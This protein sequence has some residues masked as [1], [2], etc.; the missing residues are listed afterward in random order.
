MRDTPN[1]RDLPGLKQRDF[2]PCALCGRGVAACGHVHFY[3]VRMEQ[4]VF[5]ANAIRRQHG[6][7]T[8][9]GQAAALAQALGPDEDLAK[10]VS[11]T[12]QLVCGECALT[13]D[14]LSRL[15]DGGRDA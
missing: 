4:F 12:E 11:V 10:R 9:L 8:M 1:P 6:L 15:Q 14:A 13:S 2:A 3:R 5:D 7:E